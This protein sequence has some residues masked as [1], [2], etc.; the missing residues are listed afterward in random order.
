MFTCATRLRVGEEVSD[1]DFDTVYPD[2]VR[3][4]SFHHWTPVAIARRA[5]QLLTENGASNVLDVGAG[6]GKFCI[7]GALTTSANFMGIEQRQNLVAAADVAVRR[8]GAAR[9]TVVRA[10]IATF[11]CRAFNGFYFY[12]PFQEQIEDDPCPIDRTV[13]RSRTLYNMYVAAAT[14][15]LIRAPAGTAVVTYHGFGGA[16]PPHYRRVR[17]E[18]TTAAPLVLWV[19]QGEPKTKPRRPSANRGAAEGQLRG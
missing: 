6:P 5:A 16:M 11:D 12:N 3:S 10:N 15:S 1:G 7:V 18:G 2:A 19:R 13:E 9:A 8:F 4:V 14:A 17:S